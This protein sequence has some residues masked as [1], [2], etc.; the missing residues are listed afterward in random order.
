MAQALDKAMDSIYRRLLDKCIKQQNKHGKLE[1]QPLADELNIPPG[2]FNKA[3]ESL[4]AGEGGIKV[5]QVD[6][7]FI[8]LGPRGHE[9]YQRLSKST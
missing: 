8:E 4:N 7:E 5:R 1:C 9:E 2:L 3:I 6:G